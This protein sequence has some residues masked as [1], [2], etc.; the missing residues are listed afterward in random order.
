MFILST[1]RLILLH[2]LKD[3]NGAVTNIQMLYLSN[4]KDIME[5]FYFGHIPTYSTWA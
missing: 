1:P 4:S 5:W 3:P 2:F